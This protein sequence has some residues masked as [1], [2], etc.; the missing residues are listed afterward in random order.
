MQ[1]I[2]SAGLAGGISY[3][4][5]EL[6]FFA[7]ALPVGYIAYHAST[8]IW[9]DLTQLLTD[10]EGKA[11]LLAL[12]VAYIVLLKTF[13]P[14]RLGATLILT[15]HMQVLMRLLVNNSKK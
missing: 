8:G 4:L 7:I 15:P 11:Q 6:S 5:V 3:F 13:F 1:S 14:V 12:L 9:L 2:R 10:S